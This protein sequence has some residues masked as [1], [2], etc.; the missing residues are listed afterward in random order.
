MRTARL[1]AILIVFT[2]PVWAQAADQPPAWPDTD[3]LSAELRQAAELMR[4][5]LEK[6]L[7]SV[8]SALQS[9]P[10]YE[11]PKLDENGDIIMRR[12]RPENQPPEPGRSQRDGTI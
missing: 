8:D 3:R 2:M 10:Q 6:M 9:M 7:G 1:F 11:L 12:K 5:G 4:Q